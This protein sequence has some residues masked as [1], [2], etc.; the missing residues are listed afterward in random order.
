M[1]LKK[2]IFFLVFILLLIL[3]I[4]REIILLFIMIILTLFI[5]SQLYYWCIV[6]RNVKLT[7]FY[8]KETQLNKYIINSVKELKQYIP[9]ALYYNKHFNTIAN[10]Q[11]GVPNLTFNKEIVTF[12]DGGE[13]SLDWVEDESFNHLTPTILLLPGLLGG[14]GGSENNHFANYFRL[15]NIRVIIFNPRGIKIECKVSI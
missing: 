13:V 8:Y 1:D 15:N 5:F 2:I 12:K 14:T 10:I 3:P 9:S 7:K 11:R 4:T 6:R